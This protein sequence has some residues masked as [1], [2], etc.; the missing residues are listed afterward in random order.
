MEMPEDSFGEL[1]IRTPMERVERLLQEIYAED[2]D[3]YEHRRTVVLL[4]QVADV[5]ENDFTEW[6]EKV[7]LVEKVEKQEAQ[8]D[9]YRSLDQL[10]RGDVDL[11]ELSEERQRG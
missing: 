7:R 10:E 9:M 3:D 6:D 8:L 1:P 11:E 2:L 5:M 4:R